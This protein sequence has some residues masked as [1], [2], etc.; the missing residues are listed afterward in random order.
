[1]RVLWIAL[2]FLEVCADG[3]RLMPK[4]AIGFT[5]AQQRGYRNG[6][7]KDATAPCVGECLT[8]GYRPNNMLVGL[9]GHLKLPSSGVWNLPSASEL[10]ES[11]KK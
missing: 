9:N 5:D 6:T 8:A 7:I 4:P 10:V 2:R 3:Y 11:L 1:M